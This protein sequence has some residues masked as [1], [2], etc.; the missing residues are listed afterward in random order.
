MTETRNIQELLDLLAAKGNEAY[1]GERV[2]ILE[3]SLQCAYFAEQSHASPTAVAAALLHDI[4][5]LLHDLP[6][7]IAQQGKDGWHEEIAAA[8]LS[9]WFGEE[10]TAPVRMHVAAKRYLCATDSGYISQLSLASIES[11]NIQGG[12]M[13]HEEARAF[14]ALPH[15]VLAVQLRRWD[16]QAKIPELKVPELQHYLPTLRVAS[17]A[18]SSLGSL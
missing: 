15:A 10:V 16:D 12:P 4:G 3:H 8:Y 1:F 11:L 14:D 13:S 17:K 9:Q 2:S 18:P 5:H 6:E 7:D